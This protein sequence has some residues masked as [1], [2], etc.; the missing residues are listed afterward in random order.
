MRT[1]KPDQSGKF[2]IKGLPPEDYLIVAL[3]Y[4]EP[5]EEAD[6]E[7]LERLRAHATRLSLAEGEVKTLP[8]KVR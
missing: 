3:E 1:A 7:V 6:P 8:L 4:L 5:G 2:E